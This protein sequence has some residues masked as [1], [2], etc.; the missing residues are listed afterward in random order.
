MPTTPPTDAIYIN[1]QPYLPPYEPAPTSAPAGPPS[2]P[3]VTEEEEEEDE[4][5]EED[6]EG[7]EGVEDAADEPVGTGV[8][9]ESRA[10]H[11]FA[12]AG[13]LFD[14]LVRFDKRNH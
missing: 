2:D 13:M 9:A 8:E 7:E 4:L 3:V 12:P 6:A 11:S 1:G 5:E 14:N 10:V